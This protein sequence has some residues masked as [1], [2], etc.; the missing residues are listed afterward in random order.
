MLAPHLADRLSRLADRLGRN[1]AGVEDYGVLQTGF[2][3]AGANGLGLIGIQAATEGQYLGGHDVSAS[4]SMS[5]VKT[6][7]AGPVIRT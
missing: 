2:G 5:P 6:S 3:G 4:R 7:V 1:G